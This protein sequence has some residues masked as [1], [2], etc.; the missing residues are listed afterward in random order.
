LAIVKIFFEEAEKT[1][2]KINIDG[3]NKAHKTALMLAEENKHFDIATL[4]R[5][6]GA[7][8]GLDCKE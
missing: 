1:K 8:K 7:Q 2:K 5:M 4:L 6:Q 3:E